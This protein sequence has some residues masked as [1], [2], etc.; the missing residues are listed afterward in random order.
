MTF[1]L[2]ILWKKKIFN[3]GC[4]Q[5]AVHDLQQVPGRPHAQCQPTI[6]SLN[7]TG[8]R[9][10]AGLGNRSRRGMPAAA[11]TIRTYDY[12]LTTCLPTQVCI[13]ILFCFLHFFFL[14][15][16]HGPPIQLDNSPHDIC[17]SVPRERKKKSRGKS[18]HKKRFNFTRSGGRGIGHR[19]PLRLPTT[20]SSAHRLADKRW[21]LQLSYNMLL[22]Y[23]YYYIRVS[24]RRPY[25]V[26]HN[27]TLRVLIILLLLLLWWLKLLLTLQD[28]SSLLGMESSGTA[29]IYVVK[30]FVHDN[31]QEFL[32]HAYNY[33]VYDA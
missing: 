15:P 31:I 1:S 25:N 32:N 10:G 8:P 33:C 2:N 28:T 18:K 13:I 9:S 14:R 3:G 24:V 22:Y 11:A 21:R 7:F 30:F 19:I 4:E 23:Y 27:V 6:A 16:Y 5:N 20:V 29:V 17:L 26:I 12:L